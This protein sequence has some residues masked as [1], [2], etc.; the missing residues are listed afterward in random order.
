MSFCS[1][2][3]RPTMKSMVRFSSSG[4]LSTSA[5]NKGVCSVMGSLAR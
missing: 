4:M 2:W 1:R 3:F 5:L